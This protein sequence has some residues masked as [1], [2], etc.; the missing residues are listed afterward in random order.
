M[1]DY[2]DDAVTT[3]TIVFPVFDVFTGTDN[4]AKTSVITYTGVNNIGSSYLKAY[5]SNE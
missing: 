2:N 5:R 4:G 1:C 3:S